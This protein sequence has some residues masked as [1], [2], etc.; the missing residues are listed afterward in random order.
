M[1]TKR[2]E[3][4]MLGKDTI[5]QKSEQNNYTVEE[6][7]YFWRDSY[8][9]TTVKKGTIDS[10]NCMFNY[11][12][13]PFLGNKKISEVTGQDI[14]VF[15]NELAK[16]QYSK[17]TISLIHALTTN[18]FRYAYRLELIEKNP[19]DLII[20]PRGRQKQERRVLSQTEQKILL[21]YLANQELEILITF[22]LSTGM[23]IGE[24]TGLSWENVNFE[25]NELY[26]RRILKKDR[27]NQYYIDVP[28]TKKSSRTVPLLP[29]IVQLLQ[30]CKLQQETR[31]LQGKFKKERKELGNLVFIR[32][33]GSP[34]SDIYLCRKLRQITAEINNDKI[35]FAPLTPHCLRHTFATRALESGISPKVVQELLGHSSIT[36]TLDLYTHVMQQTKSEEIQKLSSFF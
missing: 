28:K 23:R 9:L 12:I 11:Y 30:H 31:R 2:F 17:S 26:I 33:N 5:L 21:Q 24:I 32:P 7:Y 13:R 1:S 22:A 34:Y 29:Q 25:K 10:Y 3:N 36:L 20:L 15:Y 19:I 14:Q 4:L 27:S 35:P 18:L 16:N 8:K 6:W